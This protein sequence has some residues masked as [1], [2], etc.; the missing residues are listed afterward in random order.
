MATSA[1]SNKYASESCLRAKEEKV[2]SMLSS[3]VTNC[4]GEKDDTGNK[5]CTIISSEQEG[6]PNCSL[7]PFQTNSNSLENLQVFLASK[8]KALSETALR[9]LLRKRENL[10]LPLWLKLA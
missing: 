3:C 10:V 4:S 5:T 1:N 7:A 2:D 8:E 6:I 9:V